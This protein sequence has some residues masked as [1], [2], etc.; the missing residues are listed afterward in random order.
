MSKTVNERLSRSILVA[1]GVCIMATTAT[2]A[3]F[4]YFSIGRAT[5][6]PEARTASKQSTAAA[7]SA[8]GATTAPAVAVEA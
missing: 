5:A 7:A 1:M 3:G 6:Q 2:A 4:T 8:H